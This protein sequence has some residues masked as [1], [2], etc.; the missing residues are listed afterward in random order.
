MIKKIGRNEPCP[1]GSGKKYKK[2]CL[3]TRKDPLLKVQKHMVK[4][5]VCEKN[6]DRSL[7]GTFQSRKRQGRRIYFC[8]DCNLNLGCSVCKKKLGSTPFEL[9]SCSECGGVTI[10]CEDCIERGESP[11]SHH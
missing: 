9:W 4:C 8:P 1:C 5:A 10:V 2:C 11:K 3:G 6:F 7:K